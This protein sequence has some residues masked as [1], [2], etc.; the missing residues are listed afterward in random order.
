MRPEL[1]FI[2][3]V[4]P[5]PTGGGVAMRAW[6]VLRALAAEHNVRL[7]VGSP[8]FPFKPSDLARADLPVIDRLGMPIR[9]MRTPDVFVRGLLKAWFP[10]ISARMVARPADWFSSTP[11]V[12]A[13]LRRFIDRKP[14]RVIHVFRLYMTPAAEAVWPCLPLAQTE[15]DLDDVESESRKSVAEAYRLE[16]D[17]RAAEAAQREA[18][19]YEQLEARYL[20]R[21]KRVWV[22]SEL[23]RTKL[24]ARLG[25]DNVGVV[26]N[27]ARIP[28]ATPPIPVREPFTFLFVGSLGHYPNRAG[29]EWFCRRVIPILRG[30]TRRRFRFEVVGRAPRGKPVCAAG[31]PETEVVGF[32]RNLAPHYA[33]AGAVVVPIWAGGGTRIKA[34]E[35]FAHRRPVVTTPIGVAGLDVE[36]AMAAQCLRLMEQPD[37]AARLAGSAWELFHERY[38]PDLMAAAVRQN[39]AR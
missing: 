3:P 9:F 21:L 14:I 38:H 29:V 36:D 32:I 12:R 23:D 2:S 22:C 17:W 24:C 15:L 27:T 6:H 8:L 34:L 1:L 7:A 28:K 33:A 31:A 37:L 39:V 20:P 11:A 13:T 16:G 5:C 25:L 18:Q 4:V 30:L 10:S 35:A 19:L 26:P